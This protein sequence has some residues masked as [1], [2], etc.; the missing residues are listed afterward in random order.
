[1]L[2]EG[3]AHGCV[4]CN[5]G[6]KDDRASFI[7]KAKEKH[8]DKFNYDLVEYTNSLTKVKIKCSN[9]HIFEQTPGHHLAGDECSKCRGRHRTLEEFITLS[10]EKFG[11]RFNYSRAKFVNMGTALT[12]IC[13]IGHL[14]ETVP[15]VHLRAESQGGCSKCA[16]L[17]ISEQNSYDTDEWLVLAM[18]KHKG[19]Y[20]YS[21]VA[22]TRSQNKV[23]IICQK[24]GEFEQQATSH[25]MG[26]GC[27]SC[28]HEKIVA[29]KLY[30]E[31]IIQQMIL[32]CTR[33]HN[34]KYIYTQICRVAGQ[35]YIDAQCNQHGPFTQRLW[36]HKN[37][38]GCSSC[39]INYSKQQIEWLTYCSIST[40]Y[41]QHA[42]NNGEYRIPGTYWHADGY[43]PSTHTVY[44][45]Q[46]DFWHGNPKIY[47]CT[48]MNPRTGT[49]YG[50]L[51][52]K[53]QLKIAS[54]KGKGYNV[55]ELWESDWDRAK[56]AVVQIQRSWKLRH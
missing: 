34:G 36:Y 55:V 3:R 53:T 23:S 45:F 32:D 1:M 21:N 7:R 19:I 37:G 24:H 40:D 12:L 35:L 13:N 50:S 51:Y 25:L 39:V 43:A 47:A 2:G 11:T 18:E 38:G 9:G 6:V 8:G 27:P 44:E 52:E 10:Q 17:K 26:A 22:Y 20:D 49:T 46:G 41:I 5:G 14:F 54:L 4:S 31:D 48:D 33:I 15:E 29:S 56:N 16:A 42:L 30:S 28:G